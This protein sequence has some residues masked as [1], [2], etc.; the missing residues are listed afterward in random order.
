MN[1]ILASFLM[2]VFSNVYYLITRKAQINKIDRRIYL[3]SNFFFSAIFYYIV[4]KYKQLSFIPNINTLVIIFLVAFFLSYIPSAVSYVAMS[5][6]PN[7]GYSMVIQKS[8]AVFTTIASVFLFK[9][10]FS[11]I[12]FLIVV[13]ILFN[14]GLVSL[15]DQKKN[16]RKNSNSWVLLSFI[17][18]FGYGILRLSNKLIITTRNVDSVVLLFWTTLFVT[19]F[20]TVDFIIHRKKINIKLSKIDWTILI[21]IGISVSF[22]YYFLLTAEITAPNLGYVSAINAAS[23]AIFTVL[24]ALIFKEKVTFKKMIGVLGTTIGIILLIL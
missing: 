22:F 15:A 11:W 2:L 6:A 23:N 17:P 7:A 8:Y 24:V 4:I 14:V 21:S 20:S 18:F 1:W 3:I 9:S 16:S 12:K 13:F 19:I 5:K 10:S